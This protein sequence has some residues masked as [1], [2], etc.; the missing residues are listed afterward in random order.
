MILPKNIQNLLNYSK[1]LTSSVSVV[2]IY[3]SIS[4]SQ[5]VWQWKHAFFQ[6]TSTESIKGPCAVCECPTAARGKFKQQTTGVW[7]K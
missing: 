6:T 2:N 1:L 5:K 3:R 7:G 4:H